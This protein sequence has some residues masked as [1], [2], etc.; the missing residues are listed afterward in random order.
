[1]PFSQSA[2][3]ALRAVVWL[4]QNPGTPQTTHQLAEGTKVSVNYLP[5]VLQPLGRAEIVTSQRGIN[6]GYSLD[7]DPEGLSVLEVVECVDPIPRINSCP[8]K[9]GSHGTNLCPMHRA[10]DDA[11]K[12]LRQRFGDMTIASLLR[13]ATGSKPLCDS[14]PAVIP[15]QIP[16]VATAKKQDD[17]S[18]KDPTN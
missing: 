18:S 3:Y 5:K 15:I 11:L 13:Q 8:L 7:R 2:E 12:D 17:S 10:M 4:A 6:G 9:L 1:M 16:G 14:G